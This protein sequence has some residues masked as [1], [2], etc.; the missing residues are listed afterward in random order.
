MIEKIL[1]L[2]DGTKIKS[3]TGT[4]TD[5]YEPRS[6]VGKASGKEYKAQDISIKD[7]SGFL[8][9]TIWGLNADTLDLDDCGKA[10]FCEGD[11]DGNFCPTVK[12]DKRTKKKAVSIMGMW[13]S[14]CITGETDEALKAEAQKRQAERQVKRAQA[15]G[16]GGLVQF[17][18]AVT[19]PHMQACFNNA[20][21]IM[22]TTVDQACNAIATI[23]VALF[24][25]TTPSSLGSV[26]GTGGAAK[27]ADGPVDV[28]GGEELK[29]DRP[30]DV[31]GDRPAAA[32]S[33]VD[34]RPT[35][36]VDANAEEPVVVTSDVTASEE[37]G[38]WS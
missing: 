20:K 35:S 14:N 37:G 22:G 36:V 24:T 30:V 23:A 10:I 34:Q 17:P 38:G 8:K 12:V 11:D 21:K 29:K 13:R 16:G 6:G 31:A 15:A 5:V 32:F 1:K 2:D 7:S 3:V 9:C 18:I 19:G 25:G 33:H 4:I 26:G 27:K 28:S